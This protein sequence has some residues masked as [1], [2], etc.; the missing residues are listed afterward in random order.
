MTSARFALHRG[1]IHNPYGVGLRSAQEFLNSTPQHPLDDTI[2]ATTAVSSAFKTLQEAREFLSAISELPPN[3]NAK[4]LTER[5]DV[6][7][8]WNEKLGFEKRRAV[9]LS[10]LKNILNHDIK[11]EAVE[12]SAKVSPLARQ[13]L[14]QLRKAAFTNFAG[15]SAPIADALGSVSADTVDVT[16]MAP[17]VGLL[18]LAPLASSIAALQNSVAPS[19]TLLS[20]S[21]SSLRTAL[22]NAKDLIVNHWAHFGAAAAVIVALYAAYLYLFDTR[23][24]ENKTYADG[25]SVRDELVEHRNEVE[26]LAQ[27]LAGE[28]VEELMA[29]VKELKTALN[30][31]KGEAAGSLAMIGNIS[32]PSID[33][34]SVVGLNAVGNSGM[35]FDEAWKLEREAMLAQIEKLEKD[36]LKLQSSLQDLEAKDTSPANAANDS[37]FVVTVDEKDSQRIKELEEH[38]NLLLSQLE[39]LTRIRGEQ[40]SMIQVLMTENQHRDSE[41]ERL[42]ALNLEQ[43]EVIETLKNDVMLMR[44]DKQEQEERL[45]RMEEDILGMRQVGSLIFLI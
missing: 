45:R 32:A 12:S 20:N 41:I 31:V 22:A 25:K 24:I 6:F 5:F 9:L 2:A 42:G 26:M 27:M 13:Q 3:L 10:I 39:E 1:L 14:G 19:N 18:G 38:N 28:K 43:R 35:M 40:E 15:S 11:P 17:T 30:V 8:P 44:G 36:N 33:G 34:V 21:F 37:L 16:P 4:D 7:A 23:V 29:E